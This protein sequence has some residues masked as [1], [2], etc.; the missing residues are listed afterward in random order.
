[1]IGMPPF[2]FVDL[3][4]GIG[5]FHQV[6]QKLGGE[7]VL[8]CDNDKFAK[9]VYTDNY[10]GDYAWASDI[11]ALPALPPHDVLCAGFP[12]T[13]FSVAGKRLGTA[14]IAVGTIIFS[15]MA[16]LAAMPQKPHTVLLENVLGFKTIHKGTTMQQV[17]GLLEGMGYTVQ[18]LELDAADMGAPMHRSRLMIVATMHQLPPWV[19][20]EPA[21][22]G[23][24]RGILDT[25]TPLGLPKGHTIM[26]RDRWTTTRGKVFC[27][28]LH[29]P[30]YRV[31]NLESISAHS[32]GYRIY[33]AD[34]KYENCTGMR[35]HS[36]Y[37]GPAEG[38]RYLTVREMYR[39][40]GFPD[41][42]RTYPKERRAIRNMTNSISL[43]ML[44]PLA[45]WA[46]LSAPSV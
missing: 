41:E 32:Q 15:I 27:G 38:A 7:C 6:M 37:L 43:F 4:C 29:Q 20:P 14:D 25:S 46:I 28:Y 45:D 17:V 34:G 5:A 30:N 44:Q 22:P 13:T 19:M 23:T 26:P 18:T 16:L 40:M 21:T 8:A 39:M 2:T 9:R 12:C 1:M 11:H 31:A 24:I 36:V 42:F 10:S 3:C 33:H 35:R